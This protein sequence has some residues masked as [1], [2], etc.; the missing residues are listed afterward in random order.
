MLTRPLIFSMALIGFELASNSPVS[1]EPCLFV[2]EIV[3][4]DD[5][6]GVELLRGGRTDEAVEVSAHELLFPG[7]TIRV[8]GD[9]RVRIRDRPGSRPRIISAADGMVAI[10]EPEGCDI[11][12]SLWNKLE[13]IGDVLSIWARGPMSAEPRPTLSR[14]DADENLVLNLTDPQY[15]TA[16]I[17]SIVVIWSGSGASLSVYGPLGKIAAADFANQTFAKLDLVETTFAEVGTS[18]TLEVRGATKAASVSIEIVGDE[19]DLGPLIAGEISDLT[20]AERVMLAMWLLEKGAP[21]WRLQALSMLHS[22]TSTNFAAN[23]LFR[24]IWAKNFDG[25]KN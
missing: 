16:D 8:F 25:E 9:Q 1:A 12:P 13:G 24:S 11:T 19:A 17:E 21:I 22:E 2:G 18:I 14:G 6:S 5:F 23:R 3:H 20:A 10:N 4:A 15:L 7:D